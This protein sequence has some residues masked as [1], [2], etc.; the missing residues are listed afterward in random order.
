MIIIALTDIHEECAML[1]A[2]AD[3]LSAADIVLLTGDL[4]QFG[5]RSAMEGVISAVRRYSRNILAIAGNCDPKDAEAYLTEEGINLHG[6]CLLRGGLGFVGLGGAL[7]YAEKTPNE[8]SEEEMSK[9]LAGAVGQVPPGTPLVG[10]IH[11][12]PFDTLNDRI[13]SGRHVGS[14]TIRTFI[15][16]YRP[17]ICFTGHIHEARAIGEI[18]PTK[19][20]NPGPLR[21]GCW[22]YAEISPKDGVLRLEIRGAGI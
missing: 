11:Q 16:T 8:I 1:E 12:P 13:R 2:M 6:R 21:E 14:R 20:A 9:I 5:E 17:L 19:I 7:P 3:D 18:G 10:V 15:E 22:T 4:T